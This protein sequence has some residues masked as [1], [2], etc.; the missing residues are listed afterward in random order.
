MPVNVQAK[1]KTAAEKLDES[2]SGKGGA[3][4]QK[5]L[6]NRRFLLKSAKLMDTEEGRSRELMEAA[7]S[8]MQKSFDDYYTKLDKASK[9]DAKVRTKDR[10]TSRDQTL[11]R[12]M[13]ALRSFSFWF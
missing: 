7:R 10:Q 4:F 8:T 11:G 6:D 9:A 12:K 2:L 1:L 13:A 3:P 5:Q